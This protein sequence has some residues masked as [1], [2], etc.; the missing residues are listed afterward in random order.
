MQLKKSLFFLAISV[1]VHSMVLFAL[2]HFSMGPTDRF[3][4]F[5]GKSKPTSSSTLGKMGVVTVQ[6][7]ESVNHGQ[8]SSQSHILVK[9]ERISEV[10]KKSNGEVDLRKKNEGQLLNQIED[11]GTEAGNDSLDPTHVY[12]K[13]ISELINQKKIYPQ[14]AVLREEEGKVLLA[15]TLDR[16]GKVLQVEVEQSSPFNSLNQAAMKTVSSLVHFPPI[17]LPLPAPLHLHIPI[18][19][20]VEKNP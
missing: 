13:Q 3:F 7:I 17:P 20:R 5:L 10:Q 4:S 9:S 19:Y 8:A 2:V 1:S 12:F 11:S 15:L 14:D 16:E 18:N 6:V